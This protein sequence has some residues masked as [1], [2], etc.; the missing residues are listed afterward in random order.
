MRHI[1]QIVFSRELTLHDASSERWV[2]EHST[3]WSAGTPSAVTMGCRHS[4]RCQSPSQVSA[5]WTVFFFLF[6][7]FL[8]PLCSTTRRK[9]PRTDA[10]R[11]W[12]FELSEINVGLG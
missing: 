2:C 11:A 1:V 10:N 4:G 12:S 7:L 5:A 8:D 6:L 9:I 3:R